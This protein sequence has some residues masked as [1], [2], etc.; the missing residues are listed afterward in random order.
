[1]NKYDMIDW[2]QEGMPFLNAF[3]ETLSCPICR[4]LLVQAPK[5]TDC[6]H[7]FC[8]ECITRYLM[9]NTTCP[10]CRASTQ[11]GT[12][13][14]NKNVEDIVDLWVTKTRSDLLS[15]RQSNAIASSFSAKM[16]SSISE[17]SYK[18]SPEPQSSPPP[19]TGECPICH[20]HLPLQQLQTTH[21]DKCLSIPPDSPQKRRTAT[22]APVFGREYPQTK[23]SLPM[24]DMMPETK[25]RNRLKDFGVSSRGNKARLK[26]RYTEWVTI[27]NS[28]VDSRHPETVQEMR[29][30]MVQWDK[31]QDRA[32]EPH[33]LKNLDP[34]VWT[35]ENKEEYEKLIDEARSNRKRKRENEA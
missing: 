30:R 35:R 25:L 12:L 16:N 6:G 31:L 9:T 34:K 10:V 4:E 29:K 17:S 8:S 32:Q 15:A 20:K 3:E 18:N 22:M 13:R 23:L 19:G 27:Y 26:A 21:I 2:T 33:N 1:M 24:L 7:T 14:A 11:G 5:I 28:Q